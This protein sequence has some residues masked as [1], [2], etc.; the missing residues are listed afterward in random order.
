MIQFVV[1]LQCLLWRYR[2]ILDRQALLQLLQVKVVLGSELRESALC[3]LSSLPIPVLLAPLDADLRG[4]S[5]VTASFSHCRPTCWIDVPCPR[6]SFAD[7]ILAYDGPSSR[8]GSSGKL[9]MQDAIGDSPVVHSFCMV[10]PPQAVLG[11]DCQ[12]AGDTQ[13]CHAI[14]RIR[15]WVGE[16]CWK[17]ESTTHCHR[18]KY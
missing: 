8:S 18:A 12:H 14:P 16:R 1:E 7:V 6:V 5:P 11:Q 3:S 2:P 15:G 17:R 9:S 4:P 13:S 10:E